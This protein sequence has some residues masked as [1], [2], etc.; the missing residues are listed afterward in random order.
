MILF[1]VIIKLIDFYGFV[2]QKLTL[3]VLTPTENSQIKLFM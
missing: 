1:M 3:L 2:L